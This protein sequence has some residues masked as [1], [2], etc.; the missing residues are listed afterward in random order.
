MCARER[1]CVCE[2]KN[3]IKPDRM[4]IGNGKHAHHDLADEAEGGGGG[5]GGEAA[6]VAE[7]VGILE[8]GDNFLAPQKPAKPK[9][10]QH[11]LFRCFK[12]TMLVVQRSYYLTL[13]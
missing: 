13:F 3:G 1:E 9:Q 10:R 7:V 12:P 2:R 5:R 4:L 8:R 11:Q 6:H